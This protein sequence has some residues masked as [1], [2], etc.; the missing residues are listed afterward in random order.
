MI[1]PARDLPAG[2]VP[3]DSAD[4]TPSKRRHRISGGE[5]SFSELHRREVVVG[6]WP[7]L[8]VELKP[9]SGKIHR[10]SIY[11]VPLPDAIPS[12]LHVRSGRIEAYQLTRH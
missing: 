3:A 12:Q 2:A 7:N 10:Q 4:G 9:V 1:C 11:P 6:G 8:E 5:L